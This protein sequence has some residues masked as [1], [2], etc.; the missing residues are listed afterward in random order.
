LSV[1]KGFG[2]LFGAFK[3]HKGVRVKK[4]RKEDAFKL[5]LGREKA[6]EF[7]KNSMW[8]IYHHFK[9]HHGMLNW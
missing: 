5:E 9:K 4:P 7:A 1:F 2:E 6:K 8:N 3:G